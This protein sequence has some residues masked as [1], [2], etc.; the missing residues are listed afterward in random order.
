MYGV[1]CIW[2]KGT[3]GAVGARENRRLGFGTVF[4]YVSGTAGW[5]RNG[6]D[7]IHKMAVTGLSMGE[8]TGSRVF[9]YLWS[10]VSFRGQ[11]GA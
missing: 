11:K 9:Q 8:R 1:V 3:R 2:W 4:A 6:S 7:P 5:G 10:Y